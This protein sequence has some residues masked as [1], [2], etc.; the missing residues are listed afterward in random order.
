MIFSRTEE[1]HFDPASIADEEGIDREPIN[2]W[3]DYSSRSVRC[4][5]RF[6]RSNV[7]GKFRVQWSRPVSSRTAGRATRT[8]RPRVTSSRDGPRR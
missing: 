3:V 7:S 2:R 8:L 6:Y 1:E 5:D 4:R